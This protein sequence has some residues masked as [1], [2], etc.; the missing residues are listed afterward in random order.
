MALGIL[1]CLRCRRCE[2][3]WPRDEWNRTSYADCDH[4]FEWFSDRREVAE[5]YRCVICR[6]GNDV[7]EV[8]TRG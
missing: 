6:G 3:H 5:H 2:D 7:T 1:M 8:H 4:E